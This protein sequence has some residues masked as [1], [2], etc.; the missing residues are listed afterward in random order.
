M[1][2]ATHLV[3]GGESRL[4]VDRAR[5]IGIPEAVYAQ[6]KTAAQCVKIVSALLERSKEPIVVTRTNEDQRRELQFLDPALVASSTLTW[7]HRPTLETAPVGILSGGTS[8]QPIVDECRATLVAMGVPVVVRTDVGVAGIHRLMEVLPGLGELSVVIAVAGME[9]SLPTILG[10]LLPAPLIGV[11]TSTG[12]GSS[13]E[14]ITALLSML[15]SCAPGI[16]VVGIDNGY[17]AA[18][19]AARIVSTR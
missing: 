7:N 17:G 10:G 4:D 9:A 12:Y 15:S 1:K 18:C 16:S 13:F 11:P 14:G 3:S 19:A 6:G 8:D 2:E 5:R